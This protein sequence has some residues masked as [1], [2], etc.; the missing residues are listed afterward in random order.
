MLVCILVGFLQDP[1]RKLIPGEPVILV[2]LVGFFAGAT[3]IGM[4]RDTGPLLLEPITRWYEPLKFRLTAFFLLIFVQSIVSFVLYG[5]IILTGI[6]LMSYLAPVV[7]LS[8]TYSYFRNLND[9]SA[10]VSLYLIAVVLICLGVFL[11]FF[12]LNWQVLQEV[13][14]GLVIY[15]VG[16]VLKAHPG[17]MRASEIAA[18]HLGTAVCFLVIF[19]NVKRNSRISIVMGILITL[20]IAAI[21]MTGRRKMIMQILQ[22]LIFYS[23]LLL[24]FKNAISGRFV[25]V[26]AGAAL[27]FWFSIEILFPGGYSSQFDLYVQRGATVFSDA[28]GRMYHLG[29]SPIEWAINRVGFF[30]A[31]IGIGSQGAALFWEGRSIAGGAGEG[32]LGKITLEL[33]IPGL[34]LIFMLLVGLFKYMMQILAYV[35]QQNEEAF[36]IF[37]GIAAC[38]IANIPTF[39][40]ASQVYGDLFVLLIIGWLLG[41]LLA[42]PR[43]AAEYHDAVREVTTHGYPRVGGHIGSVAR[44]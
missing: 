26:V 33:G 12:G 40:V 5:S 22:F 8:V 29:Y 23:V 37:A 20:F 35:A 36:R 17:F 25:V 14:P 41:L 30:G 7:A 13:G 9:F 19:V 44:Y 28:L 18:W 16:T 3:V 6:G 38:L 1:L 31:G 10:I 42:V 21:L 4:W 15:D 27:A 32:G 39:V 34:V 24:Y 11:S 2:I 43:V